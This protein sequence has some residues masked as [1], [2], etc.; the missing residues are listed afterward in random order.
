MLDTTLNEA[1]HLNIA[2]LFFFHYSF[3]MN[4][5]FIFLFIEI[6]V[7]A[8]FLCLKP[9]KNS[10]SKSALVTNQGDIIIK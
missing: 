8:G 9:S 7:P 6:K 3:L 2:Q 1:I 5:L 10:W 4:L